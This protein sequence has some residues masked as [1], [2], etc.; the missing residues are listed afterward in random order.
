[1]LD[2]LAQAAL[3]LDLRPGPPGDSKVV[4]QELPLCGPTWI[5][6]AVKEGLLVDLCLG[7]RRGWTGA[8]QAEKRK[9]TVSLADTAGAELWSR[10]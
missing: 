8:H 1:M 6:A 10:E 5:K 7:T 3:M 9:K 4:R 2:L